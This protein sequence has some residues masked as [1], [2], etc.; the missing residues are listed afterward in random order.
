[1]TTPD[2]ATTWAAALGQLQLSVTRP[3]STRG[4]AT[5]SACASRR[6]ASSSARTTIH[7]RVARR[8]DAQGHRAGARPRARPHGRRRVR[9]RPRPTTKPSRPPCSTTRTTAEQRRRHPGL[10]RRTALRPKP[11]A[12]PRA[13]VRYLRRRR[14]ERAGPRGGRKRVASAG[15][16]RTR[17]SSSAAPG[18]AR[19]T[20][21]TPSA[22]RRTRTGCAVVYATAERFGNEYGPPPS[23]SRFDAFRAQVPRVRRPAHRRHPVLRDA[24]RVPGGV[25]PHVRRAARRRQ[26]DRRHAATACRRSSRGCQRR[27]ALAPACGASRPTCASRRSRRGSPFSARR[28]RTTRSALPEAALE[29][30]AQRCCPTVRELEGY[31]NRVL[32]HLPLIGGAASPEAVDR[33][34]HVVQ[35]RG[36]IRRSGSGQP[37]QPDDIINAVVHAYRYDARSSCAAA[38]ATGR[39]RTRAIW[40]CTSSST[41]RTRRS[42][43]S[44]ALFG[45]RDHSTVIGAIDRIEAEL[46]TR[47]ETAADLAAVRATMAAPPIVTQPVPVSA[48]TQLTIVAQGA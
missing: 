14:G 47:P 10:P 34:L 11:T 48:Q 8:A 29:Q 13:D 43:R 5:P 40:R 24:A 36:R 16:A 26:A 37:P 3:T 7:A 12:P 2:A 28:L 23:T 17:S 21:S 46:T 18:W 38:A 20:C 33:A 19:R 45:N 4:C 27:P 6:R 25:L 22:T 15:R 41:T 9:G 31:L 42:P 1:M 35:H 39:S 30:I 32:M 44:S